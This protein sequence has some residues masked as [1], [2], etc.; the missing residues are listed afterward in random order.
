MKNRF[1]KIYKATDHKSQ[2]YAVKVIPFH[3]FEA[4][5]EESE[6]IWTELRVLNHFKHCNL[7]ESYGNY[8]ENNVIYVCGRKKQNLKK[9][10]NFS[11]SRWFWNI[12]QQEHWVKC[13]YVPKSHFPKIKLY[14]FSLKF[15]RYQSFI[16][17]FFFDNNKG[18]L[19]LHEAGVMHRDIKGSN[20][21][22]N[23]KGIIKIADF[24]T[25]GTIAHEYRRVRLIGTPHWYSFFLILSFFHTH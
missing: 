10:E 15:Y 4:S 17:L 22:L 14:I 6:L 21:L 19:Y 18:L 5:R 3:C 11:C 12:V 23:Q 20:I 24:G 2:V 9:V 25:C 16:F 7:V 1:G 13:I 8:L